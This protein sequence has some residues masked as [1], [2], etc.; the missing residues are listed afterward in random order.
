MCSIDATKAANGTYEVV[1]RN[2]AV[3][4]GIDVRAHAEAVVAMG[5]GELLLN[6]VD[7]DGTMSGYD[8]ELLR[9]VSDAVDIPVVACGGA[10]TS[11]DLA[12]AIREGGASAAAAGSLFV[13]HG[14]H[15]AV[16]ITYPTYEERSAL[17]SR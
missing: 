17:F 7:R 16:L 10:G 5:A 2:A 9:C 3:R 6:S 1:I 8:T 11:E 12:I 4:T 13:F 14:R 15:R